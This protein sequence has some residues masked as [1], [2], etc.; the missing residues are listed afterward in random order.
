MKDP[1]YDMEEDY[2]ETT[3]SSRGELISGNSMMDHTNPTTDSSA[4]GP[5]FLDLEARFGDDQEKDFGWFFMPEDPDNHTFVLDYRR[6]SVKCRIVTA[7]VLA[8][9]LAAALS[10]GL[11]FGLQAA[12]NEDV[13]TASCTP[14][15]SEL[16]QGRVDFVIGNVPVYLLHRHREELATLFEEAYNDAS[17]A[18]EGLYER[19]IESGDVSTAGSS[20]FTTWTAQVNCI[21]CPDEEP[22]FALNETHKNPFKV[23]SMP[24]AE[25]EAIQNAFPPEFLD[26]FIQLVDTKV[27]NLFNVSNDKNGGEVVYM[28]TNFIGGNTTDLVFESSGWDAYLESLN[29]GDDGDGPALIYH[30]SSVSS[31]TSPLNI[32]IPGKGGYDVAVVNFTLVST[33]DGL[34]R[35]TISDGDLLVRKEKIGLTLRAVTNATAES[36]LFGVIFFVNGE[37]YSFDEFKP[38]A[39]EGND[40]SDYHPSSL[41]SR[42]VENITIRALP[43]GGVY[44][45]YGIAHQVSFKIMAG[46]LVLPGEERRRQM[47]VA[48]DETRH[49]ITV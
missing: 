27:A 48:E 23:E 19:I 5:P 14:G 6:Y 44:G 31:P 36:E 39:L 11:Y 4:G 43:F 32:P 1:F 26:R 21:G 30:N 28:A 42:Q 20:F 40:N 49:T 34:E 41:L 33:E 17:G 46:K 47:A 38:Y 3:R 10:M 37:P 7:V 22:L 29:D 25:Q 35:G 15:V 45:H 2:S 13:V 18:C 12:W 8:V 24:V 9:G 16:K